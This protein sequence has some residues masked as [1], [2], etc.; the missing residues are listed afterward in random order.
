MIKSLID[1]LT[2]K[3]KLIIISVVFLCYPIFVIGFYGYHNVTDT[4]KEKS[5]N[6]SKAIVDEL[7]VI[8]SDRLES[9]RAFSFQI[10]YDNTIYEANNSIEL[11]QNDYAWTNTFNKFLK[12]NL[13]SK[14]EFNEL[15]IYFTSSDM[16]YQVSRTNINTT[17]VPFIK[18]TLYKR[19]K[20]GK[21]S[22]VWVVC[23]NSVGSNDIYLTKLVYS[24]DSP[25]DEVALIIFKIDQAELFKIFK[26]FEQTLKHDLSVV[27]DNSVEVYS[28]N[29]DNQKIDL[30]RINFKGSSDE[31]SNVKLGGDTIY[32]ICKNIEPSN[33]KIV[34]KISSNS[35]LRDV[36]SEARIVL[37]LCI[38][39]LPIILVL[40]NFLYI[41]LVRPLNTLIRKMLQIENGTIG[42]TIDMRRSDEIGYVIRTFNNMSQQ[43]STLINK[44]FK[45]QLAIKDSEIKALQAQ[46]NPH[47]LYNTLETINW[48]AKMNGVEEISEMVG[49]L[50]SIIDANLNRKGENTILLSKE[51]EYINNYNLL[52]TKRF[53]KKIN[54]KMDISEDTLD[55]KIPKLIIQPLIENAVYHGLE[56]KKGGGTIELNIHKENNIL[57]IC[58]IDDGLGIDEKT[59]AELNNKM[60]EDIFNKSDDMLMDN[61]KIGVIN[62]HR[63]L[64]LL[65]GDEYGL[66][67]ESVYRQGTNISIKI[68]IG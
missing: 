4:L 15:G 6:Y 36:K 41:D 68:P 29:T 52:T 56:M 30:S 25:K 11:N 58:V 2:I 50:S 27:S 61:S 55:C 62:V 24:P 57:S 67:I 37:I 20:A 64:R 40:I 19:A 45:V 13:Y 38:I 60:N 43:I 51:I 26:N 65:Y 5:F 8:F 17:P 49:A 39:G 33:W 32:Y 34:I 22:P 53:G 48:K 12:A 9:V 23:R 31:V 54:F 16:I 42:V 35:L 18:D 66:K 3:S 21:G 10:L 1:K 7:S 47:F 28:F 59:L 44:V 14:Y 46:I 63:R